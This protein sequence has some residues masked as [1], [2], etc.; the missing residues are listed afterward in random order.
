MFPHYDI[1]YTPKI[2]TIPR[3]ITNQNNTRPN[4]VN[5]MLQKNIADIHSKFLGVQNV[6]NVIL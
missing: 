6:V 3:N 4:I 5:V 2:L 1:S